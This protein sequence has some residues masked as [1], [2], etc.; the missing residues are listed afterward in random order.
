ME[1]GEIWPICRWLPVTK[2]EFPHLG[3]VYAHIYIYIIHKERLVTVGTYNGWYLAYLVKFGTW[4]KLINMCGFWRL[5]WIFAL[6]HTCII[7]IYIYTYILIIHSSIVLW[8][9][10]HLTPNFEDEHCPVPTSGIFMVW[11]RIVVD[12]GFTSMDYMVSKAG[13]CMLKPAER[14]KVTWSHS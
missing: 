2:C 8:S 14:Q 9:T 13:G 6:T 4:M 7:Y 11:T 3:Y 1:N 5:T 10:Q 12:W